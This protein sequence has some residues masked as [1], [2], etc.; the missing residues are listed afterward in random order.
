[1]KVT[2]M[3]GGLLL[4]ALQVSASPVDNAKGLE[5]R[6][7]VGSCCIGLSV[8]PLFIWVCVLISAS[9]LMFAILILF[10]LLLE[11]I[12]TIKIGLTMAMARDIISQEAGV[13]IHLRVRGVSS[14]TFFEN[15]R[16]V[17]TSK[18]RRGVQFPRRRCLLWRKGCGVC[19]THRGYLL[20]RCKREADSIG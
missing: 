11:N 10:I 13:H 9:A 17:V 20:Y 7:E 14:I 3:L 18:S 6:D 16:I 12:L 19:N 1:M 5:A 4:T 2:I 8:L 15:L